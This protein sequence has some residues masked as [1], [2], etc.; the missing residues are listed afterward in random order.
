MMIMSSLPFA[1]LSGSGGFVS[2]PRFEA[3]AASR[4][5]TEPRDPLRAAWQ[6][7]F[8][9]G[10]AEAEAAALALSQSEHTARERI[11]LA[12][13]RLDGEQAE[14]LRRKLFSLVE[15]LCESAL[16]PLALDRDALARRIARAA[17]MLSRADD[18]KV[19]RLHPGDLALVDQRLPD[20]LAVVPDPALERGAIR[21]ESGSGG[22]ED[23]P[24]H[25]RRAITE[26]LAQ[27]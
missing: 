6:E 7:G 13:A 12:L 24:S 27:C 16:A 8:A 5:M 1:A 21:L 26:A 17:E 2:D 18:D 20:G 15:A 10:Q 14:E 4:I 25:W 11:E 3:G 22:V 19:L 23:G 9:A